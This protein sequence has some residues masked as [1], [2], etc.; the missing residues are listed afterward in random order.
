[1]VHFR[2][3]IGFFWSGVDVFFLISGCLLTGIMY[4]AAKGDEYPASILT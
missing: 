1:M 3:D 2:Q 4:G